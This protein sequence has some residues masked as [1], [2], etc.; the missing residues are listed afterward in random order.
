MDKHNLITRKILDLL[1]IQSRKCASHVNMEYLSRSIPELEYEDFLKHIEY[2]Q[3]EG[4]VQIEDI[5]DGFNSMK[6]ISITIDG[7]NL[8]ENELG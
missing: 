2:L 3:K 1:Y 4:Y 6:K 8:I 5:D 7:L